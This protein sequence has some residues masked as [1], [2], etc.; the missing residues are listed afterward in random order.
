[1]TRIRTAV[2]SAAL[3]FGLGAVGGCSTVTGSG[4]EPAVST[5]SPADAEAPTGDVEAPT[6]DAEALLSAHGLSGMTAREV[7]ETLD[8]DPAARPL[9]IMGSVTYD[10]VVLSDETAEV[11]LPLDG[12]EFYISAAPYETRTHDCY[13]HSLGTCQGELTNTDV[14]VSVVS[15]DGETL[16]DEDMTTYANGFVGFWVPKDISGT[17]TITKDGLTAEVPFSSDEEGATCLTTVELT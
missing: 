12:D 17:V 3:L 2:L 13:F 9:E 1:M 8:Q 10:E 6:G 7:V 4:A 14:H 15:D 11:S 16:I 5:T